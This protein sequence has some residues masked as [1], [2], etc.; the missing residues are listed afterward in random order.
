MNQIINQFFNFFQNFKMSWKPC[1]HPLILWLNEI[2]VIYLKFTFD[3]IFMDYWINFIENSLVFYINN[4]W[5][6]IWVRHNIRHV[7]MDWHVINTFCW[8]EKQKT[9]KK[10]T[11]KHAL[12]SDMYVLSIF[13]IIINEDYFTIQHHLDHRWAQVWELPL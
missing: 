3:L 7:Q 12:N 1:Q 2:C 8:K 4:M 13:K 10:V 5:I 9:N 11:S 6:A